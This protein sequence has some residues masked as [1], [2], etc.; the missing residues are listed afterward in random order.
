LE[1]DVTKATSRAALL[2]AAEKL[3]TQR[4]YASV[5][6]REL[7]EAAGVNL[8]AIQYHFGS[9]EKLFIAAI[10]QM[11][12]QSACMQM[13]ANLERPAQ[14]KREAAVRLYQAIHF[15]MD[16]ILHPEGPQVCRLIFREMLSLTGEEKEMTEALVSSVV[17]NFSRPS[18]EAFK[19]V[20]RVIVPQAPDALLRRSARSIAGQCTFY[21]SHRAFIE[22]LDGIDVAESPAFGETVDHIFRFSLRAL[23]CSESFVDEVIAEVREAPGENGGD[24]LKRKGRAA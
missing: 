7:A 10:R 2:D 8:G 23:G 12:E 24:Q 15:F 18:E 19:E 3:F 11:M 1:S 21:V 14:S 9:K 16:H 4:S 6:T 22:R 13:R 5:G 17:E 20:L